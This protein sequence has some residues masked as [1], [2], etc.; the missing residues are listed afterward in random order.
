MSR[1]EL[2]RADFTKGETVMKRI[3][4]LL[5]MVAMLGGSAL[6]QDKGTT[7]TK[8]PQTKAP[9]M[10]PEQRGKMADLHEKMAACLRSN[11]PISECH[12]DMMKGCQ[13]TMGAGG[14]PM[15]GGMGP[16]GPHHGG[17]TQGQTK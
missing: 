16:H 4:L 6:A 10:T 14:C 7:P 9:Q 17:A 2:R 3:G 5:G 13:E 8:A 15:M 11:R 1:F 12:N